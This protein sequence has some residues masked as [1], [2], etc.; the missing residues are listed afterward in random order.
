MDSCNTDDHI[1]ENHILVHTELTTCNT[2]ELQQK[3]RLVIVSER[4]LGVGGRAFGGDW[5]VVKTKFRRHRTRRLAQVYP[6]CLQE[7]PYK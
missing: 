3:Y 5:L 2:E 4:F 7:C 1:D 6:V